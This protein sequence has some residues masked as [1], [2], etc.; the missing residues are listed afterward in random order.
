MARRNYLDDFHELILQPAMVV[1]HFLSL[2]DAD[3]DGIGEVLAIVDR[4]TV[5]VFQLFCRA[6]RR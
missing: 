3:V 5:E 6:R 1:E 2:F 4:G